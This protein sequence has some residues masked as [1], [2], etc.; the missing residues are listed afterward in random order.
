[1]EIPNAPDSCSKKA[2]SQRLEGGLRLNYNSRKEPQ[3]NQPL[4]TIITVVYNGEKYLEN[5]IQNVIT[6]KYE[7][8]EYIVIDGGSNDRTLEIIKK[9]DAHIT[10]WISE[11]DRGIYDAMNK[12]WAV[13]N[14][15]SYILFLGAGDLILSLPNLNQLH[16]HT[17]I[18]GKVSMG[19]NGFFKSTSD[20]KLKLGNTLHHQ[21]LLIHKSLCNQPPFDTQYKV[22]ADY[23]LNAR[24]FNKGV[25]FVFSDSFIAYALPGGLTSQIYIQECLTIIEKNF[26]I[27]WTVLAV[28][29]YL[30]QGIKY[31]FRRISIFP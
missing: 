13:A 24:L 19:D 9:Y 6:Q 3:H 25:N 21:A 20:W 30:Y 2:C 4:I 8:I 26:G 16:S 27:F 10:F 15:N 5:T 7:N 23:D 29:Y 12:G 14:D 1:M 17:A 22:Y 28:I 18:F 11:P 31:G